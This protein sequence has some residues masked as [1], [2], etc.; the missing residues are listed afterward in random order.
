MTAIPV[1]R[2]NSPADLLALP[3]YL[4]T[5][6]PTESVVVIAMKGNVVNFSARLDADWFLTHFDQAADQV[7]NAAANIG[8][9]DFFI[10]GYSQDPELASI[11]VTEA[12]DIVGRS[13]V[14]EALV[15]DGT[16]YWSLIDGEGPFPFD[17]DC[18]TITAQAVYSGVNISASREEAIAPVTEWEPPDP[19]DVAAVMDRLTSLAPEESL[20]LLRSLAEAEP[21][22]TGRDALTLA[23]LLQDEDHAGAIIARINTSNAE[24]FWGNL[25]AARRVAPH[26][27]EPTVVALLGV[28]SWLAGRGAQAT[29]CIEQM[30]SLDPRHPIGAMLA[31]VHQ[32]GIPPQ[33]WD[34]D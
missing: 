2:S 29:A 7:L 3:S 22:V 19:T 32:K 31:D 8:E 5:F 25:A 14:A 13:R 23:C 26:L 10:L 11:S 4:F 18:S 6:H 12:A 33:K 24:C 27:M 20:D 16:R 9:C 30:A 21:A 1:L 28:A 34:E 15:T 17:P